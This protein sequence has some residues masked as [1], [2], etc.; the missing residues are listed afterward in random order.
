MLLSDPIDE[1]IYNGAA[2]AQTIAVVTEE[3]PSCYETRLHLTDGRRKARESATES[4]PPRV[5]FGQGSR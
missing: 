5:A 3:S 4:K 1:M 2:G